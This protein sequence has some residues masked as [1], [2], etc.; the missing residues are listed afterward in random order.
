MR[1][2]MNYNF[3]LRILGRWK[4]PDLSSAISDLSPSDILSTISRMPFERS[5][6][7][8]T[9]FNGKAPVIGEPVLKG[10]I[11]EIAGVAPSVAIA[12]HG[13]LKPCISLSFLGLWKAK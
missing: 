13:R 11:C 2:K 5:L 6:M 4:M 3:S 9:S 12:W 8:A 7:R 1:G 10:D